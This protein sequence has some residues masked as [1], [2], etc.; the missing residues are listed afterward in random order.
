MLRDYGRTRRGTEQKISV[1][2]VERGRENALK[3]VE[4]AGKTHC[5]R[6]EEERK[7]CGRG[8]EGKSLYGGASE[9]G[10]SAGG[11]KPSFG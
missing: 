11:A 7:V 8:E 10:E 6:R 2:V 5:S 4:G 3:A 1:R 9:R